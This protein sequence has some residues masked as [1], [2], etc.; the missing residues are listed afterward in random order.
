MQHTQFT[1]FTCQVYCKPD[2]ATL[3][4]IGDDTFTPEQEVPVAQEELQDVV[5]W[6]ADNVL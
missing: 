4:A 6:S 5:E 1:F 2:I 3:G